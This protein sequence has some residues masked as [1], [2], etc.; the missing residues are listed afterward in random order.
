MFIFETERFPLRKAALWAGLSIIAMAICAGFSYGFVHSSLIVKGD[1]ITTINNISQSITLFRAEILGWLI[2]L[3]LDTLVS[4][5][6]YIFL[7]NI[8]LVLENILSIPMAGG[9]LVLGI[10]LLSNC[11]KIIKE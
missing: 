7:E 11:T 5:S 3:I 10:W 2:I 8:T 6:T 1:M 4:W 9:E